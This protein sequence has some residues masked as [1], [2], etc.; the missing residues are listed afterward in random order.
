M[1]R[2]SKLA[3]GAIALV[4]LSGCYGNGYDDQYGYN[5]GPG[6]SYDSW[7]DGYYGPYYGGYW[8]AQGEFYYYGADRRYH[9]DYNRHFRRQQFAGASRVTA[10]RQN[11]RNNDRDYDRNG[12]GRY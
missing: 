11:D 7:Y 4:A 3:A 8:G 9:R 12:N 6:Y 2:I 1:N 5:N 10:N